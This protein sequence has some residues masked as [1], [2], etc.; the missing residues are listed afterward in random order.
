MGAGG[1]GRVDMPD[2]SPVAHL[3]AR[4]Q[5]AHRIGIITIILTFGE[6]EQ[7]LMGSCRAV[8]HAFRHG[9]RF[10][11][12]NIASQIPT[13]ILKSECQPPG[14][15]HQIF[16][17]ESGRI[18]R[19]GGH[20]TVRVFFVR[21]S[22]SAVSACVS[23]ANVEPENSIRFKN[24]LHFRKNSGQCLQEPRQSWL[25]SDLPDNPVIPEPPV[26]RR[27]DHALHGIRGKAAEGEMHIPLDNCGIIQFERFGTGQS[28]GSHAAQI[29]GSLYSFGKADSFMACHDLL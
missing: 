1:I 10:V 29:N 7:I 8:F 9:I 21:G 24:T 4:S 23:V 6:H 11:P 5:F 15:S 27:G 2:R 25:Q 19:A 22:P 14:D 20:R 16:I 26:G 13:G 17:F 18:V 3:P 12:D 28:D